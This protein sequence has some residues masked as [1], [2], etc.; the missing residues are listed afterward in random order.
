MKI[1][2]FSLLLVSFLFVGCEPA[3]PPENS[4]DNGATEAEES[5]ASDSGAESAD[6]V[7]AVK[8][9]E[10]REL[11]GKED[12]VVLDVR[13][14]EEYAEGH[15][16]G[17][18]NVDFQSDDF[19]EEVGELDPAKSYVVH[20]RS[21]NRSSQAIPILEDAGLESLYHLDSGMMGWQEAGMPVVK[22]EESGSEE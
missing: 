10:A 14:P 15:I 9:E 13:T 8:P 21:G 7:V 12:V 16:E 11:V 18:V 22:P 1:V 4:D 17:A 20:C 3:S 5:A 2:A 6:G 19:A